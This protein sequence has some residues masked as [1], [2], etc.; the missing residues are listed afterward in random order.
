MKF[1]VCGKM[2]PL[3]IISFNKKFSI[4]RGMATV[5]IERVGKIQDEGTSLGDLRAS[6]P[7][8][9]LADKADPSRE[10]RTNTFILVTGN[11]YVLHKQEGKTY[12][13]SHSHLI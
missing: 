5:E 12:F 6:F 7:G 10:H 11:T 3:K 8:S 2:L 9:W 1:E 13:L 4:I